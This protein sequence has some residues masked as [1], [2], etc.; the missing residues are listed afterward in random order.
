MKFAFL[1]HY[2]KKIGVVCFFAMLAFVMTVSVAVALRAPETT[3][4]LGD[5]FL[6]GYRMGR[7]LSRDV[8]GA[9]YWMIQTSHALLL[10]SIAFY[11]LAKEKVDDEYMDAIRWESLRLAVLLCIGLT[12][13]AVL[14]RVELSAKNALLL[15]FLT[16]LVTF[17]IKK[18]RSLEG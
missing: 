6:E 10:L 11:M 14:M 16:Y 9:N 1:P 12:L 5:S 2:F 13:A 15:L 18:S 8:A 17:R 4:G 7:E 3:T